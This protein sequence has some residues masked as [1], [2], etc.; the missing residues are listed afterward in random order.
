MITIVKLGGGV[1]PHAGHF[2]NALA[3]IGEVARDRPLLVV[4]GGGPFADAVRAIDRQRDLHADVAHWMAVLAM[5]QCAHLVAGRL[6]GAV[7]VSASVLTVRYEIEAALAAGRVPVLAPSNWLRDVDPLP[8]S[9]DVTSDSVAAWVS[10]ELGASRLVLVKP[11]GT[12]PSDTADGAVVDAYFPR[13]LPSHVASVI[14]AADRLD[15]LRS[16]LNDS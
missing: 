4:P 1:L 13:A 15:A 3:V 8:H 5:D 9:W 16:A 10:G 11:P 14:V 12:R 6:A 2:D 7:V